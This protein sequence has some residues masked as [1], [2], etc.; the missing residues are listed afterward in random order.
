MS[1]AG[2]RGPKG[3]IGITPPDLPDP[4]PEEAKADEKVGLVWISRDKS[5]KIDGIFGSKQADDWTEQ[6]DFNDPE[7][8]AY[9]QRDSA[10]VPDPVDVQQLKT[11]VNTPLVS[12]SQDDVAV[13]LK[14]MIRRHLN[15]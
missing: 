12:I 10:P 4:V 9:Q 1:W 11:F 7:V 2:M 3:P 5:G 6:L 15:L 13:A 14:A 8:V